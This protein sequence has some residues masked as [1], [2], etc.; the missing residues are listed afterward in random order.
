MVISRGPRIL[1]LLDDARVWLDLE[2]A[3]GVD[4]SMV[5]DLGVFGEDCEAMAV[6][7][8]ERRMDGMESGEKFWNKEGGGA[9]L[10]ISTH[11]APDTQELNICTEMNIARVD[12]GERARSQAGRPAPP[13]QVWAP[14]FWKLL[15]SLSFFGFVGAL[16]QK[17]KERMGG[18]EKRSLN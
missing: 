13:C 3:L 15:L 8:E 6:I 14:V 9:F 17:G 5:P 2:G 10:F 1:T 18:R 7:S 11:R 12:E 16:V 4:V